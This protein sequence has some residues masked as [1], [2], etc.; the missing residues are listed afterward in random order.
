MDRP[1]V[2]VDRKPQDSIF[3][4]FKDVHPNEASILLGLNEG[5]VTLDHGQTSVAS[6][7]ALPQI[8]KNF[9][10][11]DQLADEIK[12]TGL[13]HPL[14]IAKFDK[15]N[16]ERYAKVISLLHGQKV[17]LANF[18]KTF[19]DGEEKYI[20]LIAG[21]RR[22]RAHELLIK[23][24]DLPPDYQIETKTAY[25]PPPVQA[26]MIQFE[27]NRRH[28]VAAPEEAAFYRDYFG[29]RRLSDPT[30]NLSRMS[31]EVN[32]SRE[33]LENMMRFVEEMPTTIQGLVLDGLLPWGIAIQLILLKEEGKFSDEKLVA[34][35]IAA[36]DAG[37]KSGQFRQRVEQELIGNDLSL[38]MMFNQD[39]SSQ[40]AARK[41]SF[42]ARKLF[43]GMFA[44]TTYFRNL[45]RRVKAGYSNIEEQPI[46]DRQ[47]ARV[48]LMM[49][50]AMKEALPLI[51]QR[52]PQDK[53]A[54]V[55]ATLL[56]SEAAAHI[57][58]DIAADENQPY[59]PFIQEALEK[60]NS[61]S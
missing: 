53:R 42:A 29:I 31:Q 1:T 13:L 38:L 43:E 45:A 35:A 18:G 47:S 25:N 50:E 3:S 27:E 34:M 20:A 4:R 7:K 61:S 46:N 24:G 8:R 17:T 6:I 55:L 9:T 19:E 40:K 32:D 5:F 39:D 44:F 33:K 41:E 56:R 26:I 58:K 2:R 22:K 51:E 23:R 59:N 57:L 54:E 10:G 15:A 16:A 30:Y 37:D 48:F 60:I 14:I 11:I 21:E 28:N 36:A 49:V 12:A 52:I